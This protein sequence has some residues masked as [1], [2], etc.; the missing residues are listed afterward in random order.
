MLDRVFSHHKFIQKKFQILLQQT[1]LLMVVLGRLMTQGTKSISSD[2]SSIIYYKKWQLVQVTNG[3]DQSF[4]GPPD[5]GS[6]TEFADAGGGQVTVTSNNHYLANGNSI[7]VSGT[8]NYNGDYSITNVTTNTF[9]IT[10]TW[11]SDDGTGTYVNNE[12]PNILAGSIPF[13]YDSA[14]GYAVTLEDSASNQIF[15]G[16]GEWAIDTDAGILT[17]YHHEDVS[18]IVSSSLLPYLSFF[19]YR[20]NKGFQT[21]SSIWTSSTNE[22]YFDD[23]NKTVLIN[24]QTRTADYALEVAGSRDVKIHSNLIAQDVTSLSDKSLKKNIRKLKYGLKELKKINPVFLIGY[25]KI[26][27][28]II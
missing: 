9:E 26:N 24:E 22:A 19:R 10:E 23:D 2:N 7:T 12:I 3:N 4:K 16:T 1:I 17:F 6:I 13:N 8:T 28:K 15:D 11:V 27:Q 25:K 21:V 20:G 14:G 5:G 18:S